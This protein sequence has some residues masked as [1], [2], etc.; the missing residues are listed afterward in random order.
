MLIVA[1][2][3]QRRIKELSAKYQDLY[4]KGWREHTGF[5]KV[6]RRNYKYMVIENAGD[7][8]TLNNT[9]QKY[10]DDGYDL[11]R[12][13]STDRL[14]VFVKSEEVKGKFID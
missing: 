4:G 2:M 14:L 8:G 1:I 5:G 6:Y 3:Q 7:N 9:A 13:K 10:H 11:D 12:E